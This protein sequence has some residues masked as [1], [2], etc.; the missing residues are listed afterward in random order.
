M[1]KIIITLI[2]ASLLAN[3]A[4]C[5][6]PKPSDADQS[7]T[8]VTDTNEVKDVA[9]AEIG[10]AVVKEFEEQFT[11]AVEIDSEMLEATY[12]VKPEWVG[13]SYSVMPMIGFNITTLVGIRASDGHAGDVEKALED[14]A[15]YFRTD[16]MQY[17]ANVGKAKAAKVYR[18]G[19]YVFFLIL[20]DIDMEADD[21]ANYETAAAAVK[22][23]IE[24]IDSKLG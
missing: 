15:E 2:L 3:L 16:A 21:D 20:G 10:D 17:P 6:S 12:G 22:K 24:I 1:K 19:D 7:D 18:K 11:G 4:A 14:Y 9:I 23:A 8:N 13:E 5:G